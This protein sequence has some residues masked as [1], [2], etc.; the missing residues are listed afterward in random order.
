[1]ARIFITGSADGLGFLAAKQLIN[2]GH[3]VVLHARN[4]TRA[5]QLKAKLPEA[6]NVLIADFSDIHAIHSLANA[7][8]EVGV[9]DAVIHNAGIYNSTNHYKGELPELFLVNS[10]APYILTALMHVP[11]RLIYVSSI[12]HLQGNPNMDALMKNIQ[13]HHISYSD[14]KLH[15]LILSMAISRLWPKV[16]TNALHPGWV[17]TKMGGAGAPDD[18]QKGY[19][20][21]VWLAVSNEA[22][23]LVRGQYF[24]HQ[25]PAQYLPA[26]NDLLVQ[27]KFLQICE[28]LSGVTLPM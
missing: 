17:P 1:M 13:H 26:A 9:F 19:E 3:N 12:M 10:L 2:L 27:E 6:A 7:A 28:R 4:T 24:Y 18:L 21:Q 8:N 20:T 5:E 16:Y 15:N 25:Q 22:A 11:K 23:A 14:T